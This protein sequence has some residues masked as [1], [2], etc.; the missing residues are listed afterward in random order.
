MPVLRPAL[1]FGKAWFSLGLLIAV[2]IVAG[3][4]LPSSDLPDLRLSDKFEHAMSYLLL[5]FW[6]GSIVSRR[7]L[8]VTFLLLLAFGASMEL[9]Q[10]AMSQ[11]RHADLMDMVA[12]GF[13][14]ACGLLLSQS[15]LG[16]WAQRFES[17]LAPRT[18]P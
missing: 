9:L 15:P 8:P 4:L 17:L 14:I 18:A 16:N 11:G 5:S 2:G 7:A 13:G 12:N 1:R 3:S 6:F 10:G